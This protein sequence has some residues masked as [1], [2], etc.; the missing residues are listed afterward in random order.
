MGPPPLQ[1]HSGS[2]ILVA[3]AAFALGVAG[4][5][6]SAQDPPGPKPSPVDDVG[7]AGIPI[8]L[9]SPGSL[10]AFWKRLQSPDFVLIKGA[11]YDAMRKAATPPSPVVDAEPIVASVVLGGEVT[12][13]VARLTLECRVNVAGPGPKWVPVGADGLVLGS[14]REAERSLA[15]R[16]GA[17][18]GWEVEV[19]GPGDHRVVLGV[20]APVVENGEER[21]LVVAIPPAASTA[22]ALGIAEVPVDAALDSTEPLVPVAV[23]GSPGARIDATIRPR[24]RIDLTWRVAADPE[25]QQS[26]LL[27]SQGDVA[28]DV[29]PDAIRTRARWSIAS[30]RGTTRSLALTYNGAEEL[31]ELD[32]DGRPLPVQASIEGQRATVAIPLDVPLRP[33]GPSRAVGIATRRKIST[34]SAANIVLRGHDLANATSQSGALSVT[35]SGPIWVD[36]AAGRGLRRIDPANELPADLRGRPG[37][38]LAYRIVDQPYALS[39]EVEPYPPRIE[40]RAKTTVTVLPGTIS[41]ETRFDFRTTPGRVFDLHFRLPGRLTLEQFTPDDAVE[42][43]IERP[44]E[45]AG[46][47]PGSRL[48]IVR[49]GPRARETGAF[50]IK[51][52]T[53]QPWES[54]PTARTTSVAMVEPT[55]TT[56]LDGRV[57]ILRHPGVEADLAAGPSGRAGEGP[58]RGDPS[59]ATADW[60]WP[61]DR[62]AGLDVDPLWFRYEGSPESIPLRLSLLS[63]SYR[64]E[65]DLIATVG[66]AGV[67]YRQSVQLSVANGLLTE[68]ELLVPPE[69]DRDWRVEEFPAA[70]RAPL[71]VAPDGSRRYRVALA[72]GPVRVVDLHLA[73]RTGL[74]NPV[75]DGRVGGTF[76]Q[77]RVFPEA[78]G[79]FRFSPRSEAGL[80]L[81]INREGWETRFAATGP[82]AGSDAAETLARPGPVA[83]LPRFEATAGS[84]LSL[85]T[86]FASRCYVRSV[87][88][89]SELRTSAHYRLDVHGPDVL[90]RLPPGS[91]WLAARVDGDAVEDVEVAEGSAGYRV[92]LD[93]G[94]G[95]GPRLLEVDYGTS[96]ATSEACRPP[97]LAGAVVQEVYWELTV[98]G[99][100]AV[101]GTPAGWS[102]ENRWYWDQYVWKRQPWSTT[103][104]LLGWVSGESPRPMIGAE[105]PWTPKGNGHSYL[106]RRGDDL[107]PMAALIAPRSV[108]V[109]IA[110][111]AVGIVGIALILARPGVRPAGL[112]VV[113]GSILGLTSWDPD[114]TLQ[115]LQSGVPGLLLTAVAGS[116]QWAV[117][118][119]GGKARP[120]AESAGPSSRALG[121][122][123]HPVVGADDST[124]IRARPNPPP[125]PASVASDFAA[126]LSSDTSGSARGTV[127]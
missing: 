92:R 106:F 1:G 118:R 48:L 40:A 75:S 19:T 104:D 37:T 26:P 10:D 59:P 116:L 96:T 24:S 100:Q 47:P 119:R 5:V 20:V 88:G 79:P 49:L 4:P 66:R 102:D 97:E 90:I 65:V 39:L 30:A 41:A 115:V 34:G 42:S 3:F 78:S 54:S 126:G 11:T 123:S 36:G 18:G 73:Y 57:A 99:S 51:L 27:T 38:V 21:R 16:V 110:S 109:G 28:V 120:F 114:V 35:Q 64:S 25:K 14:A 8:F 98:S 71:E 63:P 33:N 13:R 74:A 72:K 17:R 22:L 68:V 56:L 61:S 60:P 124:A 62:P 9:E 93:R 80:D 77:I 111:G 122:G 52:R 81:S 121:T 113:A 84:R 46:R 29:T 76:A 103:A 67:D 44:E 86:T 6:R 58:L 50:T 117:D 15:V 43:S 95:D 127:E 7:V 112:L 69:V 125:G 31:I 108:L 82:L 89:T 83:S 87:R 85:P 55:G 45:P 94:P 23:A 101:I 2:T 70:S 53:R 12:A 32:L 91:N 107:A 105:E